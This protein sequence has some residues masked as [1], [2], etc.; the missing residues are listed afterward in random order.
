MVHWLMVISSWF[1]V[2]GS[3]AGPAGP[4]DRATLWL[5]DMKSIAYWR[6]VLACWPTIVYF[7]VFTNNVNK[8]TNKKALFLATESTEVRRQR[9]EDGRKIR[10]LVN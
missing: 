5:T 1:I 3:L 4:E 2:H 8:K 9:T 6:I 10:E 7:N